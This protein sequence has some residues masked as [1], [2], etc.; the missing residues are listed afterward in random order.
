MRVM[1]DWV[2]GVEGAV[3]AQ[4]VQKNIAVGFLFYFILFIF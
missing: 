1:R 3:V 4:S 2:A